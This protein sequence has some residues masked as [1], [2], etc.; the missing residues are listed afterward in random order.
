MD[1]LQVALMRAA[2][3]VGRFAMARSL[4]QTVRDL[5]KRALRRRHPDAAQI[6]LDR[7]FVVL[8]YGEAA[9]RLLDR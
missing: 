6:E 4:T 7:A 8:H 1:A 3:P 2:G 5:S 9:V